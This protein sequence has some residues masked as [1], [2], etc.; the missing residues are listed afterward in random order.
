MPTPSSWASVDRLATIPPSLSTQTPTCLQ[1]DFPRRTP[2]PLDV[3][4]KDEWHLNYCRQRAS[5]AF[6]Q[7]SVLAR[8]RREHSL[9]LAVD[10]ISFRDFAM[11][12]LA[13]VDFAM[14]DR[15]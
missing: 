13:V 12:G 3:A 7:E 5:I 15:L 6:F 8:L 9:I 2:L 14:S 11:D 1:W 4:L 10:N